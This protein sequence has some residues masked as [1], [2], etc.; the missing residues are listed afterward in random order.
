MYTSSL[1][2][3]TLIRDHLDDQPLSS[4]FPKDDEL[5]AST[6]GSFA[7]NTSST[8]S[9][10][11]DLFST[12]SIETP[13]STVSTLSHDAKRLRQPHV[14]VFG[15]GL[16]SPASSLVTP[17]NELDHT[18]SQ[19]F[20]V[21][22]RSIQLGLQSGQSQLLAKGVQTLSDLAQLHHCQD[23]FY[24]LA[25]CYYLGLHVPSR[26]PDKTTALHW[27]KRVATTLPAN[28][29]HAPTLGW[30]QYRI[31]KI[32][33]DEYQQSD[34]ALQYYILS[35]ENCNQCAQYILGLHHQYRQQDIKQAIHWYELSSRQGYSDAQVSLGELLLHHLPTLVN[36]H[37]NGKDKL[38]KTALDWLHQAANQSNAKAHLYLGVVYDEGEYVP[39]NAKLAMQH[40]QSALSMNPQGHHDA[41]EILAQYFVGIH[42][43]LGDLVPQNR[44]VAFHHL[45]I[46]ATGNYAPAQRAIG[47]MYLEGTGVPKNDDKAFDWFT[48]AA[49]QGDVQSLGLLGQQAERRGC[50]VDIESAITMYKRAADAG[51]VAAQLSLANLLLQTDRRQ[52]AFPWF[53]RAAHH[54]TVADPSTKPLLTSNTQ[55][56]AIVGHARQRNLARLMVARYK[57]NG[58]SHV[59][60]DRALAFQE[61]L[62]LSN[63]EQLNEAHYWVAACYEEGVPQDGLTSSFLVPPDADQAFR[64]YLKGALGGDVDAQ[65]QV[66]LM[67]ANGTT[68]NGKKNSEDAFAWYQKAAQRGHATAQYSLGIFYE[69][70]VAPVDKAQ[71]D[72]AMMWYRRASQQQHTSAMISLAQLLLHNNLGEA[73]QQEALDW[74]QLACDQPNDKNRTRAQR[75]LASVFE[76]GAITLNLTD[77]ERY[78]SAWQL[79]QLAGDEGDP[80]AFVD[81]A[82]FYENGLGRPRN[83]SMALQ[84]LLQA[85]KLGYKKAKMDLAE[86]Y[87]RHKMY[88]M[89]LQMYHQV[90]ES[91]PLLSKY[92]W[93]ARLAVARLALIDLDD[94]SP[95]LLLSS[96]QWLTTMAQQS[97]GDANMETFELLGVCYAFGKGTI[98]DLG[99]A[100]DCYEQAVSFTVKDDLKPVQ[101]RARYHLVET[102]LSTDNHA[103]AWHHLQVLQTQFDDMNRISADT[104]RWGRSARYYLGYLYLHGDHMDHDETKAREWLSQAAAEG[105]G[106]A[107]LELARLDLDNVILAKQI[108]EQGVSTGHADCMIELALML[109]RTDNDTEDDHIIELLERAK[110][111][112]SLNASFHLT[113]Y[114]HTTHHN[115]H[116]AC[117]TIPKKTDRATALEAVKGNYLPIIRGYEEL[118]QQ[119]HVRALVYL[120]FIYVMIGQPEKA[121]ALWHEAAGPDF[122]ASMLVKVNQL[123]TEQQL[124]ACSTNDLLLSYNHA[125]PILNEYY[126]QT[127]SHM[128]LMETAVLGHLFCQLGDFCRQLPSDSKEHNDLVTWYHLAVSH[129]SSKQ[130]MYQLGLHYQANNDEGLALDWFRKA[131]ERYN[132]P[133]A[134][135][136]IGRCHAYG[137]AGL[138]INFVAARRYFKLSMENAATN[139]ED[140]GRIEKELG[141]AMLK[142]GMDL[143]QNQQHQLALEE[144][145]EAAKYDSQA[146][147]ELGHLYHTGF[148]SDNEHGDAGVCVILRN[149]HQ[150]FMC[151][152]EAASRNN[153]MGALIVGSYYEEGYLQVQDDQQALEWY[154]KA[155]QLQCGPLA[156][157]AIGKL[158][159]SMAE[160][161]LSSTLSTP[162]S[163]TSTLMTEARL[164]LANDLYDEAHMWLESSVASSFGGDQAA[165]AKLL[166]ALYHLKGL[167]STI[168]DSPRGV[169]M[170]LQ[171]LEDHPQDGSTLTELAACYDQGIGVDRDMVQALVYWEQA[172]ATDDIQALNRSAD[173]YQH[174]LANGLV[175]LSKAAVYRE[176]A[177]ALELARQNEREK[178]VSSLSTTSSHAFSRRSSTASFN[179]A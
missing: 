85:E 59:P 169:A 152:Y 25:E 45:Q 165:L 32:L 88:S 144:L 179:S 10:M 148:S 16:S 7:S 176:R 18:T 82:R 155:H 114:S 8:V 41:M 80:L 83:V 28:D 117:D 166:L 23:A 30:A 97:V 170:L 135:F 161:L 95:D 157:L 61:F 143:W 27:Y 65:F 71:T 153:A 63:T 15:D 14:P 106:Q 13:T 40:Y 76:Q 118:I 43:L 119:G 90:I 100:I 47:L 57:F 136:Q 3:S 127:R 4:L 103:L 31:A 37:V 96:F 38:I 89:A 98:A 137:L 109:E 156:E 62:A 87:N 142:Q 72:L 12:L 20:L 70:G 34:E 75:S 36:E 102:C 121:F 99:K 50:N 134:Q 19:Q 123:L 51:S 173:I 162:A 171:L 44:S 55:P 21:A 69:R 145:E 168:R 77:N 84:Q 74:L 129:G 140:A 128:D 86:L 58:W 146:L 107:C 111:L 81:M 42:Y 167:G 124:H 52:E 48:K 172:A 149:Y 108:L 178:S 33:E 54:P 73:A 163:S 120:G 110:E 133:D 150:A 154:E 39:R 1:P 93:T 60:V 53:Q 56:L 11:S 158:K 112:G 105:D 29:Q 64:Y 66:A 164:N 49:V 141:R 104:R 68:A 131:A 126:E 174:G 91:H 6:I 115:E 125:A 24:P 130:G 151:Y 9:T 67:L 113:R 5:M 139:E 78:D 35:A 2:P 101:L 17:I 132:H 94:A 138:D 147:V 160:K 46:A 79:L 92:G 22:Q 175:D 159:Y 116:L 26:Q 177:E 122:L